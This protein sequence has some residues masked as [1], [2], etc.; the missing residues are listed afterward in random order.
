MRPVQINKAFDLAI[1]MLTCLWGG[2]IAPKLCEAELKAKL[3]P[4]PNLISFGSSFTEDS[5]LSKD[6]YFNICA[7]K[8]RFKNVANHACCLVSVFAFESLKNHENYNLMQNKAPVKFLKHLRNAAAH[9]NAFNFID[10][11]SK[12]LLTLTKLNGGVK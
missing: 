4:F 11:R 10:S 2:L 5:H 8:N 3:A 1:D 9:G 12:N 6:N 7:T